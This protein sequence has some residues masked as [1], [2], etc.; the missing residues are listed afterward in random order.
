M[1]VLAIRK[2]DGRM[3]FNPAAEAEIEG[4]DY[5]VVMGESANLRRLEQMFAEVQGVKVLTA[6]QMREVDRRTIE[7]G[8]PG[9]ILMENA[10]H[11]VVEFLVE[12]FGP[13]RSPTHRGGVRQRA[14]TAAM[15]WWWRACC[16]YSR[17]AA[18]PACGAWAQADEELQGDAAAN[19]RMLRG[20]AVVRS[21]AKSRRRCGAPRS[22]I[23][24]VL[25]TGLTGPA[26]GRAAELIRE[27][28]TGFPDARIVAVD[29]PSGLESD[30][31]STGRRVREGAAHG[32]VHGSEDLPGAFAG[33]RSEWRIAGR[34]DRLA[35]GV[36]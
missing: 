11:R 28:N 24:G 17:S 13:L 25:G 16:M 5:L 26:K 4:D 1:I 15:A 7:L 34:A 27:I 19:F 23:D 10:G 6:A 32:H 35:G 14:I 12:R 36:I 33:L 2:A 22:L 20:R 21:L 9:L 31:G 3:L 30:S 29:V 18:E 8:I